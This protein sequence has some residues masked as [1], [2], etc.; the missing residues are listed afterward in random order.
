[1]LPKIAKKTHTAEEAVH[2]ND[3]A[4]VQKV[5]GLSFDHILPV[6]LLK[7]VQYCTSVP[8]HQAEHSLSKPHNNS[9]FLYCNV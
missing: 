7:A 5:L 3:M 4:H 1:M 9:I 2:I 6:I 8:L